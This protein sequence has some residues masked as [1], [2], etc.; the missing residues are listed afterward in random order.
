M[1]PCACAHLAEFDS[2]RG[3]VEPEALIS[4]KLQCPC[5]AKYAF[6][7]TP[8]MAGK[9]IRFVCSACGLDSSDYVNSL[10]RQELGASP[11]S[12]GSASTTASAQGL[13]GDK[14]SAIKV[15]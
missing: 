11:Q 14:N 15:P 12:A 2:R 1:D 6:D 3:V 10:I 7:V 13:S 8:E 9:P 5:G 4:M